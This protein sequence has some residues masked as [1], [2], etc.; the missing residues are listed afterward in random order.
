MYFFFFFKRFYLF[1]FR[2]RGKEGEREGGKHQ[3]QL[4]LAQ[5]PQ[6]TWP[7]TQA[8]ACAWN[9]RPPGSQTSTQSNE[10]HQPG[11]FVLLNLLTSSPISLHP[12]PSGNH[13]NT[14]HIHESVSVVLVSLVCCV[15]YII[16]IIIFSLFFSFN[17]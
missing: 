10:P 11:L 4:L 17:C 3:V 8:Y 7:V 12:L 1:I 13:Q 6:G 9:P 2:E 15:F 5:P 14:L 16:I